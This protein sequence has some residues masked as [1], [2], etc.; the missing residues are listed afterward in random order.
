MAGAETSMVEPTMP[1]PFP[2]DRPMPAGSE[3]AST[4]PVFGWRSTVLVFVSPELSVTL[5]TRRRC[6]G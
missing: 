4:V 3:T 1:I 6:E 2:T 5:S